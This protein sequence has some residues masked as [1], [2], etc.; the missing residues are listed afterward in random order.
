LKYLGAL[1]QPP[2]SARPGGRF[3]NLTPRADRLGW[4]VCQGWT[5]SPLK[6][7]PIKPWHTFW[8]K[9]WSWGIL[10]RLAG[11]LDSV[12]MTVEYR[13]EGRICRESVLTPRHTKSLRSGVGLLFN[14]PLSPRRQVQGLGQRPKVYEAKTAHRWRLCRQSVTAAYCPLSC[15]YCFLKS[16]MPIWPSSTSR[17]TPRAFAVSIAVLNCL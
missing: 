2:R 3:E 14:R 10:E 1:P 4:W 7:P 12:K 8:C 5:V 9:D 11:I 15:Y 6:G 13:T 17:L 16:S